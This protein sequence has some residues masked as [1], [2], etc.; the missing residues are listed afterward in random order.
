LEGNL[1]LYEEGIIMNEDGDTDNRAC[2]YR[3]DLE[4]SYCLKP[5]T[6][7]IAIEHTYPAFDMAT[8]TFLWKPYTALFLRDMNCYCLEYPD[9]CPFEG[10]K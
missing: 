4:K 1:L 9:V 6:D 3:I 10:L 8:H 2:F 5:V 7:G